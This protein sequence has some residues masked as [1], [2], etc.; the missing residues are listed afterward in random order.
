MTARIASI[1]VTISLFTL[2]SCADREVVV[3]HY[4]SA[5][6][7]ADGGQSDVSDRPL[8]DTQVTALNNW[9]N[10]RTDCSG[11]S[12]D[13]PDASSVDVQMQDASGQSSHLAIYKRDDGSANA[14]LYVGNR[15]API[16]CRLTSADVA[17]LKSALNAQ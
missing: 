16:H 6:I 12:T 3:R 9:I 10:T 13:I 2:A 1:F 17:T 11:M 15:V 4:T 14:Y 7:S 5:Q 8:T